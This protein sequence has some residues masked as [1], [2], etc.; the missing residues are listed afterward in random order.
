MKFFLFV[1]IV[2]ASVFEV[3][4]QDNDSLIDLQT[5]FDFQLDSI[6]RR[7]TVKSWE[8]DTNYIFHYTVKNNSDDTLN[9]VTNSCFYYNLSILTIGDSD[10][11]INPWGGCFA[12]MTTNHIVAPGESMNIIMR[13]VTSDLD[14]LEVGDQNVKLVIKLK[15]NG[16]NE[17]QVFAMAFGQIQYFL[18]F[19]GKT[20]LVES[21]VD[22]RRRSKRKKARDL[23]RRIASTGSVTS[24]LLTH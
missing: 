7:T 24:S 1:L 17:Y 22:L 3:H 12:N 2:T 19:E 21:Y 14:F 15:K 8:T 10:Y 18:T 9:Y 11:V 6:E 5:L 23:A 4:A 20:I 13:A 16:E